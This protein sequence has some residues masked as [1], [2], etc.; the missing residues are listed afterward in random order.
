MKKDHL[1]LIFW[2]LIIFAG[3]LYIGNNHQRFFEASGVKTRNFIV[4]DASYSSPFDL[5]D[6]C[7]GDGCV[8]RSTFAGDEGRIGGYGKITG[9][10]RT[11]K[12]DF[13]S[14]EA[15]SLGVYTC[16]ALV[17]TGGFPE[18]VDY[19]L[20][21]IKSNHSDY[22]IT[23]GGHLI[24]PLNIPAAFRASIFNSTSDQPIELGVIAKIIPG[25]EYNPCESPVD[26]VS[27]GL[28]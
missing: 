17:V 20:K 14:E 3:G 6:Y 12:E 26:L 25:R 5:I 1:I 18:F 15:G 22:L 23:S 4:Q 9:Y 8:I 21:E 24:L 2:G 16:D 10:Y 28:L 13:S 19:M 27:V 11:L 7:N